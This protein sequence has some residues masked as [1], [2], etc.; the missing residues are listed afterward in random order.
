MSLCVICGKK[1]KDDQKKYCSRVCYRLGKIKQ[2]KVKYKVCQYCGKELNHLVERMNNGCKGV[3]VNP[4]KKNCD[5]RCEAQHRKIWMKGKKTNFDIGKERKEANP[6]KE[7]V[8]KHLASFDAN[9]YE[10]ILD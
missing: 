4:N 7:L 5:K 9:P 1:L 2:K 6:V 10:T 8:F 3:F